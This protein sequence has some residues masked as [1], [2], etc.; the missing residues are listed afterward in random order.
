MPLEQTLPKRKKLMD[1]VF[2]YL[3]KRTKIT[4]SSEAVKKL[5]VPGGG[6]EHKETSLRVRISSVQVAVH[7]AIK[8]L[9]TER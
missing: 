5:A 1:I 4:I 7:V 6:L 2:M 8:L 9:I 3:I